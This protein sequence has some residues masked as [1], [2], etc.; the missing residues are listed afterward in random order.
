MGRC[1]YTAEFL[2][3]VLDLVA[4]GCRVEDVARDLGISDQRCAAGARKT[5][6]TAD[7]RAADTAER[8]EL[9]SAHRCIRK[10]E[11]ELAAHRRAAEL[12]EGASTHL[13]KV[14]ES[15]YYARRSRPPSVRSVRHARLTDP[16]SRAHFASRGTYGIRRVHAELRLGQGVA[17]GHQAASGVERASRASQADRSSAEFPESLLRPIVL[18]GS[19]IATIPMS[20]G[21]PM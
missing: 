15:G 20:Y 21:S 2:Q 14:S 9:I 4:A 17:V 3:R 16:I 13:P 18:S 11:T 10:L 8:A 19:S 12:L 6:S 1:G 7:L 5:E